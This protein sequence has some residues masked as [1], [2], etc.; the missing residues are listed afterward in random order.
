MLGMNILSCLENDYRGKMIDGQKFK[1]S[2]IETNIVRVTSV[3]KF[4]AGSTIQPVGGTK[5]DGKTNTQEFL[6]DVDTH[7]IKLLT[8]EVLGDKPEIITFHIILGSNV[9]PILAVIIRHPN[10]ECKQQ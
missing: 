7:M 2:R 3:P 4:L 9:P 10:T 1:D 8:V 5:G 6:K